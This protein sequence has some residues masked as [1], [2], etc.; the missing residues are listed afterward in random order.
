MS[1]RN[2]TGGED[3]PMDA[4][5]ILALDRPRRRITDGPFSVLH[6]GENWALVALQWDE[7]NVLGIR[8]F[9]EATGFP[10]KGFWFIIPGELWPGILA[11]LDLPNE[12]RAQISG[13]LFGGETGHALPKE[14]L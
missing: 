7:S 8:W 1:E 4:E 14:P 9:A 6:I 13:F 11:S 2:L 3:H 5:S 10:R 12:Y